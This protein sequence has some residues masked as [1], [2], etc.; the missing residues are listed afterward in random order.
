MALEI[1]PFCLLSISPGDVGSD[2]YI[3]HS[4]LEFRPQSPASVKSQSDCRALSPDSPIPQFS[5]PQFT[6]EMVVSRPRS[7]TPESLASDW[8]DS[9]LC[10]ETLFDQ[11]RPESPQPVSSDMRLREVEKIFSYRPLSPESVSINCDFSLFTD[12]Y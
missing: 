9:G 11:S 4:F 3:D 5:C 10:P 6:S 1:N 12:G 2:S 7:F 8:D